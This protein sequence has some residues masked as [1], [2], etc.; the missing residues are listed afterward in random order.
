MIDLFLA[1]IDFLLAVIHL[2]PVSSDMRS[3]KFFL[4]PLVLS[5]LAAA[6]FSVRCALSLL[7]SPLCSSR[8][9]LGKVSR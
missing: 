7:E 2:S 5:V 1:V 6:V 3:V 9:H 8:I 4:S